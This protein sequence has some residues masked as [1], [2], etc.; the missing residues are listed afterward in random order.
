ML[1]SNFPTIYELRIFDHDGRIIRRV[2]RVHELKFSRVYNDVG[3]FSTA[4]IGT[5]ATWAYNTF[6]Y[7]YSVNYIAQIYR[8]HPISRELIKLASFFI[9]LFNPWY[10]EGGQFFYHLGGVSLD[11]LLKQRL[12]IP[13]EDPRYDDDATHITEAGKIIDVI[14]GLVENH[15][16]QSARDDRRIDNLIVISHGEAGNGGGRWDFDN[17][18]DTVQE[19]ASSDNI[20]FYIDY[21][22]NENTLE[23]HVGRIYADRRKA[24]ANNLP[25]YILSQ[26]LGNLNQPALTL[27]HQDEQNFLYIHQESE[28]DTTPRLVLRLPAETT[29]TLPFNRVEFEHNNT[30][31]DETETN[32][33]LL[34]DGKAMLKE[35][36]PVIELELNFNNPFKTRYQVDWEFG[37]KLNVEF[38]NNDFEFYIDKLEISISSGKETITPTLARIPGSLY[39][40]EPIS[41]EPEVEIPDNVLTLNGIPI[42]L[43]GE[44]ITL[45]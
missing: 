1:L 5:D 43:E 6:R 18:L 28:D 26:R 32:I 16:G 8:T 27:N 14:S 33:K 44:Q 42:T 24:N 3:T 41:E 37:D 31:K 23:F 13:E 22:N 4:L 21:N 35:H 2:P 15:L 19:L 25:P 9:R 11:I 30:R 38:F 29:S 39:A 12:L 10:D 17:L 45:T 34:T 20:D 7:P 36:E 40:D